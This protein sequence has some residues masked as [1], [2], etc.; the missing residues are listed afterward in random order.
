MIGFVMVAISKKV[1]DNIEG[2]FFVDSTC[3]NCDA[4]RKFAPNNYGDNGSTSFIK[5]Q[6]VNEEELMNTQLAL[7]SCPVNCIGDTSKNNMKEA[8]EMLPK[9]LSD[10]IYINGF[11]SRKSYGADS[12]FI[13]SEEGN[14]LI[15]SPQFKPHLVKKF[16]AM[17]GIKYIFLSHQDDVADSDLYAKHFNATT[18]IHED[19]KKAAPHA[20]MILTGQDEHQFGS[21]KIITVPGHTKGHLILLW[22]EHALF[23]GDHFAYLRSQKMFG[24]FINFCWYDWNT[25]VKSIEKMKSLTS[26]THIYPGHGRMG[27]VKLGEFPQVIESYLASL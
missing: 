25:Q 8:L 17:G 4:C 6:P 2:S 13:K 19:D 14:W 16:E 11:N 3:I 15:D 27:T 20:D 22:K 24:S 23:T 10:E 7:L 12:Y 21:A 26:V 5:K 1:K 18:I 9:K